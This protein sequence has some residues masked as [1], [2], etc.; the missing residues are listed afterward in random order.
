M[1][2]VGLIVVTIIPLSV[3]SVYAYVKGKKDAETSET[4]LDFPVQVGGNLLFQWW[5]WLYRKGWYSTSESI[6]SLTD[7]TDD[8]EG[9][10]GSPFTEPEE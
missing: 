6:T 3:S 8:P 1:I 5:D 2:I 7:W 9:R 10:A 4:G